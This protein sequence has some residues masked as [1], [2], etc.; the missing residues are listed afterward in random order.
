MLAYLECSE[1]L[2]AE[3]TTIKENSKSTEELN[4][5]LQSFINDRIQFV[6][7][8]KKNWKCRDLGNG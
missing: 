7:H 5:N 3:L 4:E 6:S 1:D 2:V 8:V